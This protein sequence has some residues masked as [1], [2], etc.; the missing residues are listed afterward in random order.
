MAQKELLIG[1]QEAG[2]MH[3]K[4]NEFDIDTRFRMVKESGVFD[5]Y[6]KTPSPVDWSYFKRA[7]EK[8]GVP[9]TAGGWFYMLGRDEPLLEWHLRLAKDMGTKVQNVQI[10]TENTSGRKVTDDEVADI[11]MWAAELGAKL[12]V[13]PCFEVHVNMWSE[14]LGRV[15]RVAQMVEKRGMPFNMTL[16]H[17]HVIF[18]IDNPPEQEVQNMR[19]DVESGRLE[20]DPFKK[21]NVSTE[22]I[23]ANYVRHAH[24]RPAVPNGPVNVWAV[25]NGKP[26]RGIQY[27]F[28]EPKPGEWHSPWSAEKLEPWK[29]VIRQL[30]RHHATDPKSRLRTITTELIPWPDYG[31]GAK[32]SL[33]EHSIAVAKWIRDEW[34][35]ANKAAA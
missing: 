23:N 28:L 11:Y 10:F 17:S 9:M 1:I 15:S 26:G 32:Y 29:E 25:E 21:G 24:A 7:S 18:K 6:D 31:A 13:T 14:H 3:T 27:P 12:G 4:W 20:L 33:F 8:H 5:Y 19:A 34:A 22:W 30:L 16:D 35:K 2:I